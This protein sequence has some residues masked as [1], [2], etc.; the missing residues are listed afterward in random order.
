MTILFLTCIRLKLGKDKYY[1]KY[2]RL[3]RK[4]KGYYWSLRR[5]YIKYKRREKMNDRI[6]NISRKITEKQNQI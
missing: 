4:A 1:R 5:R 6:T 3:K 2:A